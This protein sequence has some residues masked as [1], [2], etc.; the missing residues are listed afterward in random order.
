MLVH[1]FCCLSASSFVLVWNRKALEVF[2]DPK[3]TSPAYPFLFFG[4]VRNPISF[5]PEPA[6]NPVHSPANKPV[7]PA[8]FPSLTPARP[9]PLPFPA[10]QPTQQPRPHDRARPATLPR[11]SSRVAHPRTRTPAQLAS[12]LSP[13]GAFARTALV[14]PAATPGPRVR[15]P[16]YLAQQPARS[17]P[18]SPRRVSLQDPHAEAGLSLLNA[19]GSSPA[20][21]LSPT[22]YPENPSRRHSPCSAAQRPAPPWPHCSAAPQ[23]LQ[24]PATVSRWHQEAPR[25]HHLRPR[26]V[27]APDFSRNRR[28]R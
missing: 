20:A 21:H 24:T 16:V 25:S 17:P 14:S 6:Q 28:S 2:Q 15:P 18:R 3:Q 26:P 22:A 27:C 11:P 1:C 10:A 4:P 5:S 12:R 13:R 23:A 9:T 7:Q 8:P 19:P